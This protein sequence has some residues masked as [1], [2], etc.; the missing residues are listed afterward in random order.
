MKLFQR[1][2]VTPVALGLMLPMNASASELNVSSD[3][4]TE[5][6][7]KSLNNFSDIHPSDW[8]YQALSSLRE[9][10]GCAISGPNGSMTRYEAATLL[11]KCLQSIA[12]LN[13]EEKSLI[14]EFRTELAV[15]QGRVDRIEE[16]VY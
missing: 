16:K 2:L 13:E 6:S 14:D 8:T 4:S 7:T 9:R 15:I 1:L 10:H 3:S 11:N 5:E 12:H